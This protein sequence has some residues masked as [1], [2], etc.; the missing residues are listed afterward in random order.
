MQRASSLNPSPG[1][2][3]LGLGIAVALG[4]LSP[5]AGQAISVDATSTSSGADSSSHTW[6]HTVT[7]SG[8]DR[9]LVVG[10]SFLDAPAATDVTSVTFNGDSLTEVGSVS[11]S[12]NCTAQIWRLVNPDT[13][14]H[15]ISV[16]FNQSAKARC[17]AVSYLNVNQSTPTGSFF[18]ASGLNSSPSVTVTG[19]GKDELA[20]DT[21]AV[22]GNPTATVGAG[23]T[24]RWNAAFS[25][26]VRTAGS[27]E[28]GPTPGGNVTMS[29]SLSSSI[30]WALGAVELNAANPTAVTVTEMSAMVRGP[31]VLVRWKTASEINNLGFHVYRDSRRAR[32]NRSLIGGSITQTGAR[33]GLTAGSTY[34]W[35]DPDGTPSSRYWIEDVEIGGRR[36]QHG[37]VHVRALGTQL[38]LGPVPVPGRGSG[39]GGSATS[40]PAV[41][42][43]TPV[44]RSSL[45]LPPTGS[46]SPAQ[47]AIAA[48]PGVKLQVE[49]EGWYEVSQQELRAA[50]LSVGVDPQRLQLF[51]GGREQAIRVVGEADGSFDAGD[52]VGFYGLGLDSLWSDRS[53]YWLVEGTG[54]GKRILATVPL[55]TTVAAARSFTRTVEFRERSL[56]FAAL[57][58]GEQSNFFGPI[59][60]ETPT[61]IAL[62]LEHRDIHSSAATTL[63]VGLQGLSSG[64]HRVSIRFNGQEVAGHQYTDHDSAVVSVALDPSLVAANNQVTLSS[65][66]NEDVSLVDFVRVRYPRLY[67]AEANTLRCQVPPGRPVTLDGFTDPNVRVLDVTN[68]DEVF[69]VSGTVRSRASDYSVTVAEALP[70]LRTLYAFTDGEALSPSSISANVPSMWQGERRGAEFLIVGPRRFRVA[71]EPLIAARVAEGWSALWVDVEDLFDEYNFGATTPWALKEFLRDAHQSWHQMPT[72]VLL[73]GDATYDPREH[74]QGSNDYQVPTK[75]ID[76]S[77]IEAASDDW[78]VDFDDD[79]MPNLAIGRMPGAT[80]EELMIMV[81]KSLEHTPLAVGPSTGRAEVLLVSDDNDVLD[82]HQASVDLAGA[83]PTNLPATIVSLETVNPASARTKILASFDRGP[84]LVNYFGHGGREGWASEDLIAAA[85]ILALDN[86]PHCPV[87]TAMCCFNG[88]F[89]HVDRDCLAELFLKAPHGGAVAVWA[90]SAPTSAEQQV[91]LAIELHRRPAT[92]HSTLGQA[93]VAAK[94]TINNTDVRRTWILFGDPTLPWHH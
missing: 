40:T 60:A 87:V 54:R 88:F 47:A 3:T 94:Q 62:G 29:W 69:E 50:G 76:T 92:T 27:T 55:G 81:R 46:A 67:V 1:L 90:A 77:T 71:L 22:K 84:A 5:L 11:Q 36:T 14:T 79:G 28:P 80:A 75:L 17:G 8:A 32:V 56:Y 25:S 15:T 68:P 43:V 19:V 30:E 89:H 65:T 48:R 93:I 82:F 74:L 45:Q 64:N 58:N 78:F 57:R 59:V 18:S 52:S 24:Q 20:I 35:W 61:D 44:R 73:V 16:S 9:L 91:T 83:L 86:R 10:V 33:N 72:H 39:G 2:L 53:T 6:S 41:P 70:R 21:L 38:A 37:P 63:I 31:G 7:S 23:Q 34:Q 85:E 26:D 42:A 66:G 4:W 12:S 49:A 13:G 51:V